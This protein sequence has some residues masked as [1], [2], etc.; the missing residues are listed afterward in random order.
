MGNFIKKLKQKLFAVTIFMVTF[1]ATSVFFLFLMLVCTFKS[2]ISDIF[3]SKRISLL[4]NR[5]REFTRDIVVDL[6]C[7]GSPGGVVTL[8]ENILL[9]M[10]AKRPN[11]R[12]IIVIHK[13]TCN[14]VF[15]QFSRFKNVKMVELSIACYNYGV[16]AFMQRMLFK[17]SNKRIRDR[18]IQLF[19]YD[20]LF[21]D[22]EC[23][24]FWDPEGGLGWLNDFSAVAKIA[25]I[26]DM[27]YADANCNTP[28]DKIEWARFRTNAIIENSSKIITV[29]NFSKGKILKTFKKDPNF[30]RVIYIQMAQ[31]LNENIKPDLLAIQNVLKKYQLI[32]KNYFIYLSSYWPNKNHHRLLLAFE[33]YLKNTKSDIK[34]ILVGHGGNTLDYYKKVVQ[35]KGFADRVIFTGFMPKE[36]LQIVLANALFFIHPSVYEGFGMPLIEAMV[37]GIPVTCSI[38]GSLP[39]IASDAA[40]FFDPTN[41][42]DIVRAIATM[43]S[44][45]NL[46][47][48]LVERGYRQAEKFIGNEKMIDQYI[49]VFEEV[50]AQSDCEKNENVKG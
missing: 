26:H 22:H 15:R 23:D 14:P 35:E 7:I 2:P 16:D 47:K 45:K 36:D 29:S 9:G 11:W 18:L 43:V 37:A 20:R 38:A 17:I 44:S 8:T 27:A 48:I 10:I 5:P 33:K 40:L 39:E 50:M 24:L 12:F 32:S 13:D 3:T 28:I 30:V 19:F 46:R 4:D 1:I 41:I 31:R 6:S 49:R 21:M 42:D 25:T 34:L